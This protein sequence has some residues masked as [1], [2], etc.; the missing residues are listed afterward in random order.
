MAQRSTFLLKWFFLDRFHYCI[1]ACFV[2]Y[3]VV[4]FLLLLLL[5]LFWLYC[6][7]GSFA[8]TRSKT[9]LTA[10]HFTAVLHARGLRPL[11]QLFVSLQFLHARGLRP[12]LQLFVSL[13]FK[14]FYCHETITVLKTVINVLSFLNNNVQNRTV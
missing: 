10:I 5:L 11:L 7:R 8:C 1:L 6:L 12:L 13:P 14:W 3:E 2:F 9:A 4:F